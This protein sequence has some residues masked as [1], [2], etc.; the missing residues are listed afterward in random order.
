MKR[1]G[2]AFLKRF[3]SRGR[4][5]WYR[6][7]PEG[8]RAKVS[9]PRLQRGDTV[10]DATADEPTRLRH[11]GKGKGLKKTRISAKVHNEWVAERLRGVP[12]NDPVRRAR[13]IRDKLIRG[14]RRVDP[15]RIRVFQL[16][17]SG[18]ERRF[19][20]A[21][22]ERFLRKDRYREARDRIM[23]VDTF[24]LGTINTRTGAMGDIEATLWED[25][26]YGEDEG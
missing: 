11:G 20:I 6:L 22:F 15:D 25:G 24:V 7:G 17:A 5:L 4:E 16:T 8:S 21:S 14:K 23:A 18:K 3:D 26:G 10:L 9:R 13:E 2:R 1:Q 12:Q 19:T